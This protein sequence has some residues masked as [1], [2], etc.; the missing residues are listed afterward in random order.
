MDE[1]IIEV[2]PPTVDFMSNLT[3][4]SFRHQSLDDFEVTMHDMRGFASA[5]NE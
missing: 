3:P 2:Q 4:H 5:A 1:E